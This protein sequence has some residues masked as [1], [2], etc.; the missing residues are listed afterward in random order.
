MQRT[1]LSLV[2]AA[3][4]T[5][6]ATS[7]LTVVI[8]NGMAAAEG[9]SSNAFPWGR[10]GSGLRIQNIYDT[11]NF[12]AQGIAAR[13]RITRLRWRPNGSVA[14]A[15][16]NYP[17]G[18]TVKLSTSPL[19][20]SV[21][22]TTFASNQGADLTTVFS[23]PVS[24]P[25]AAATPGPSP[26]L[27]D[28]P[29][30][31]PFRYDPSLGDLNI[32]TDLPVQTFT[33]TGLQLDVQGT[34]SSSSRVFLSTGYV[35]GGPNA[36]TT[37]APTLS[38]GVVVEV[39][40]T[41]ANGLLAFFSATP[42]T[43]ATPLSVQFTDQSFS[44]DP[45]GITSWAWDFDGDSVIDSN[46]QNPSFLYT[47][48]GL[49]NVSLTV[50]DASH[51][52]STTTRNSF[53]VTDTVTPDFTATSLGPAGI[54]LFTDTS[55]PTPTSWAWDF[56]GDGVTDSTAQSPAWVYGSPCTGPFNVRLT[57]NRLCRGP[58]A[59]TKR[60]FAANVLETLRTGTASTSSGAGSYFDV[61]VTNPL[62]INICK[63]ETKTTVGA[64][65]A[66]TVNVFV[67]PGTWVGN[68]GNAAAWR[69]IGS[70]ATVG[71]A[72]ANDLELVSFSPPLYL[73]PGNFGM[74][75]QIVG[76]SPQSQSVTGAVVVA[77]ADLTLTL[78][79]TG[80]LGGAVTSNREW[81]GSFAYDTS[82]TGGLAGLG[83]FGTGCAGTLPVSQLSVG[84]R[85]T[86]GG[87]LNVTY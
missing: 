32:E 84:S 62:G 16:S 72:N 65:V 85:P 51:P 56:D 52:A 18:A 44:S 41:P 47:G 73:P 77:N 53:V 33:G 76:G 29:L 40:Y 64:G 3:A 54:V 25:A 79:A 1:T 27:I 71:A 48:C 11:V 26:F 15:A 66:M 19:D 69:R 23:G 14:S 75:V 49:F 67:T 20:W 4:F 78:G 2:C 28:I 31:T 13:I 63:M 82:Q 39:T 5:G 42:T 7:Q 68:S 30:T 6:S 8:P 22:S 83:W 81:N 35:N 80:I 24:W 36:T 87:T 17:V 9:I 74:H 37:F 57:V 43:G 58:F 34:G 38:H 59:I 86:S 10:G 45:G 70:A 12:P 55:T 50:N 46:L 60:V 61:G 21:P